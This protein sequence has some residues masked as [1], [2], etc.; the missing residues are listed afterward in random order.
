MYIF[1]LATGKKGPHL[2]SNLVSIRR[3]SV[4]FCFILWVSLEQD[5]DWNEIRLCNAPL[6]PH[7]SRKCCRCWYPF[8]LSSSHNQ[9]SVK[10]VLRYCNTRQHRSLLWD[11][12]WVSVSQPGLPGHNWDTTVFFSA[13]SWPCHSANDTIKCYSLKLP[14]VESKRKSV[15]RYVSIVPCT[16]NCTPS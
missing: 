8:L 1:K 13:H 14:L 6:Q 5:V 9:N 2:S 11:K 3:S 4:L 7:V 15:R 10:W 12:S 16:Q